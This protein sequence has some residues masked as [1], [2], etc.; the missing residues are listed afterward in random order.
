MLVYHLCYC[1][2]SLLLLLRNIHGYFWN[3]F[4]FPNSNQIPEYKNIANWPISSI[5]THFLSTKKNQI[6]K[7]LC[8]TIDRPIFKIFLKSLIFFN[9]DYHAKFVA[10]PISKCFWKFEF[11]LFLWFFLQ[12]LSFNLIWGRATLC[13]KCIFIICL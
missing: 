8:L 5:K 4:V 3:W 6:E 1:L 11:H 13:K 2:Q 12:F 7:K 10:I 9:S